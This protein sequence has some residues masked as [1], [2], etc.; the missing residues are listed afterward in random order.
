MLIL[1]NKAA[2]YIYID[3]FFSEHYNKSVRNKI[4][5]VVIW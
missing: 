4:F 2:P 3:I 5:P 1:N